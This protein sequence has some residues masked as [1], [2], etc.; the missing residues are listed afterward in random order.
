M[1]KG[2]RNRRGRGGEAPQTVDR[3]AQEAIAKPAPARVVRDQVEKTLTPLKIQWGAQELVFSTDIANNLALLAII[4]DEIKSEHEIDVNF[5]IE[6]KLIEITNYLRPFHNAMI[7]EK[8]SDIWNRYDHYR[9]P[10]PENFY[11]E[12]TAFLETYGPELKTFRRQLVDMAGGGS[13]EGR[14]NQFEKA[15]WKN[16]DFKKLLEFDARLTELQEMSRGNK[17]AYL[18]ALKIVH[19]LV[20][21]LESETAEVDSDTFEAFEKFY[22][23]WQL[24]DFKHLLSALSLPRDQSE[25]PRSPEQ[26]AKAT[27]M[28]ER[29]IAGLPND[30][31]DLK[32]KKYDIHYEAEKDNYEGVYEYWMPKDF[33]MASEAIDQKILGL[34][35]AKVLDYLGSLAGNEAEL[36]QRQI[37]KLFKMMYSGSAT[38]ETKV[39]VQRL[40]DYASQVLFKMIPTALLNGNLDRSKINGVQKISEMTVGK[41]EEIDFSQR[42]AAIKRMKEIFESDEERLICEALDEFARLTGKP[43]LSETMA[44]ETPEANFLRQ[45]KE[46]LK[47]EAEYL[48][49]LDMTMNNL[50]KTP[51]QNTA[52]TQSR[53]RERLA[54]IKHISDSNI[55]KNELMAFLKSNDPT[56]PT[57]VELLNHLSK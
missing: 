54:Q 26:L 38:K 46:I 28:R 30:L 15:G 22:R 19:N 8:L 36:I 51:D 11:E 16:R 29:W 6:G 40:Q 49:I 33:E 24:N 32:A 9:A 10:R 57:D 47:G 25:D 39:P 4:Q 12:R 7:S 55:R 2:P 45:L 35:L 5:E 48:A 42:T 23:G 44:P 18:D 1:G 37:R 21:A 14:R 34:R 56:Q 13:G 43:E 17:A 50:G 52:S 20:S 31:D 41:V 53:V 27:E 3:R